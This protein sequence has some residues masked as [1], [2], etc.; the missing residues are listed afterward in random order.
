MP[1]EA[2]DP[3]DA[4]IVVEQQ[5]AGVLALRQQLL[6]RSSA[7]GDHGPELEQPKAPAPHADPLLAEQDGP[8]GV[9]LDR[10]RD[11]RHQRR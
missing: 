4:R 11:Q 10:Q 6:R 5:P 9:E 3:G 7:S 8:S 1:Q 2:A